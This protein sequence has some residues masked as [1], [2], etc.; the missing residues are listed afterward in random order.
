MTYYIR[1]HRTE[2]E[3]RDMYVWEWTGSY[4]ISA[5]MFAIDHNL[6]GH[7]AVTEYLDKPVI[8]GNIRKQIEE[9]NI[10]RQREQ[11]V[12]MLETMQANFEANKLAE[13]MMKKQE[14]K[15]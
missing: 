8:D 7:K 6:S 1:A 4:G 13:Q 3:E 5:L 9:N 11:F 10:Q 15:A 12:A 14:G 2:I